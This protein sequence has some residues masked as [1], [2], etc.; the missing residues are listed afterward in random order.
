MLLVQSDLLLLPYV[1]GVLLG[2]LGL[3]HALL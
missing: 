2:L 1:V 3:H